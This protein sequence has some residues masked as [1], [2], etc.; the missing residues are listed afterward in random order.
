[1][2]T[3]IKKRITEGIIIIA[4]IITIIAPDKKLLVDMF[5]IS[6]LLFVFMISVSS[7]FSLRLL[8]CILS[9]IVF[10]PDTISVDRK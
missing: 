3:L 9:F 4:A 10:L 7:S 5:F 6:V 2:D 1:M 8:T